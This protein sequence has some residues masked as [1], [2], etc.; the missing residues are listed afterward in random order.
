[1]QGSP[2]PFRNATTVHYEIPSTTHQE[3]GSILQSTG[4]YETSVKVYNVR[5]RLVSILVDAHVW[6]GTYAKT[7]A[8]VDD[9]GNPV[10]SGVYYVKL[11]IENRFIT[12]RLTLL[13]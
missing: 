12:K 10:A 4:P 13:K 6:P 2:N 5:G 3:D 8:A 9:H 11:Q 7:W 1:L